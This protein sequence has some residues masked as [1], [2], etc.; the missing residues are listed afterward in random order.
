MIRE[1][2]GHKCD[3]AHTCLRRNG[4]DGR[5]GEAEEDEGDDQAHPQ[6]CAD[7]AESRSVVV[8]RIFLSP[9]ATPDR[10]WMWASGARLCVDARGGGSP[11]LTARKP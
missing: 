4:R 1:A 8:G 2:I 5:G 6:T 10:S 3:L 9:E 7:R 11:E